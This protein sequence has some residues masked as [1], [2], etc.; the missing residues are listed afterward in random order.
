VLILLLI[1]ILIPDDTENI[2]ISLK[3]INFLALY[4]Q[5][6]LLQQFE[7]EMKS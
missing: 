6:K 7:L 5:F 1:G 4:L 2:N 3:E